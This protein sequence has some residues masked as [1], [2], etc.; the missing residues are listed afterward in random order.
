MSLGTD[1]NYLEVDNCDI[2]TSYGPVP[3]EPGKMRY[4]QP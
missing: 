4:I 2:I 3:E 1:T